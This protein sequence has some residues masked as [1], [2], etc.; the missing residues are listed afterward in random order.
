M[1]TI[2]VSVPDT[3]QINIQEL[4][5]K[6]NAYAKELVVSMM[7]SASADKEKP[8]STLDILKHINARNRAISDK[9]TSDEIV[10]EC[11]SAWAELYGA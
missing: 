1:C 11:K 10:A 7:L 9:I 8:S 3:P 4:T 2:T 6:L 5:D